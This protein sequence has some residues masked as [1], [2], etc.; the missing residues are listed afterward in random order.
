MAVSK[1]MKKQLVEKFGANPKDTGR[2]EVQIAI[3]TERI[4]QLTEHFKK[5]KKDFGSIRGLYKLV[6]RRR[7][8]LE[9]LKR[10]DYSRYEAI[11]KE[12][13]LRK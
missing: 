13:N 2:T 11:I 5:H 6:G 10:R 1:E 12:L 9:Y 3:L 7:R 8:L 4:K